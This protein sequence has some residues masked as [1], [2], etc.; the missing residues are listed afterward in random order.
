MNQ[1]VLNC[2]SNYQVDG[3]LITDLANVRYLSGFTGSN[4]QILVTPKGATFLTD[5][6]YIIQSEQEVSPEFQRI[7]YPQMFGGIAEQIL[8]QNIKRLL[9]EPSNL[10]VRSFNQF[11]SLTPG[12][13]WV[14]LKEQSS[15]LRVVK[16]DEEL[17]R[18]RQAIQIA[19]EA[20]EETLTLLRS[21]VSEHDL[22]LHLEFAMK[23]RGAD[24]LSF[25]T[26]IA[27][28]VRSA[29]PHGHP[30]NKIIQMGEF[31]TFDC[32]AKYQ[33]YCSDETITVIMGNPSEKQQQIYQIVKDAHDSSI[34]AIKP[35]VKCS[36]IDQIARDHIVKA[37][38]GKEFSHRTGH[39]V[40]LEVHEQPVLGAGIE[41]V[42]DP[43][44]VITVEP[45][46]YLEGW[47]GVRIEDMILVTKHGH[48]VLT[49]G[50][51]HLRIFGKG[52][53]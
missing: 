40:G 23:K 11:Q 37:G 16:L 51:K 17:E 19:H 15:E 10:T 29:L 30:T 45:G 44:M 12:V 53:R 49:K 7:T 8:G 46:I 33:G 31:V 43:G 52:N 48:E 24:D 27:S 26:I 41:R 35:G 28:G 39:G 36:L 9:F 6:R 32:G 50:D 21:G 1:Q 42:L 47:G 5:G 22:A 25:D 20:L 3:F 13:T 34:E 2:L 14:P 4:G 38:Y 18:I